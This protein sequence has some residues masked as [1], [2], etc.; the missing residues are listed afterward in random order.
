M[1]LRS[2]FG[3]TASTLLMLSLAACGGGGGG[4]DSPPASFTIGG[5]VTGLA[6][7]T[8]IVL[9]DNGNDPL[10]VN[11]N[12][13]FTFVKPVAANGT[14]LV[15]ITT[16]PAGQSCSVANFQGAG[17]TANVAN[18]NITCSAVT[19]TIAGTVT[20]LAAGQNVVL[21]NN[22]ADPTAVS[23]DGAFAFVAPVA[24]NGSYAVTVGTQPTGQ[25]CTVSNGS[26]AGV[27]ADITNVAVICSTN[28]YTIGG[29]VTGLASGQ[30]VTLNNNASDPLTV[31]ADGT[32]TFPTAV[33]FNGGYAVTVG[34]QP[35][36]QTCTVAG[37]SGAGVTANVA[38]VAVICSTNT[39]AIGGTVAGLASGQQVTLNDNASDPLTVNADGTFTFPTAVSFNGSYAVTVGTQP[40]G[41]T[42][43]VSG[44]SGSGVVANITTVAVTCSTNTYAVGGTITG[45]IAGQQVTLNNNASDPLSINANGTFTFPTPVTFNGS[46]AITVGTQPTNQT[47]TVTNGSGSG[48]VAAISNVTVTCSAN[49]YTVSGTVS[50]LLAGQQ[51]TLNNN[52]ANP[53]TVITNGAFAFSTPLAF[54]SGYAVTVGTQPTNQTCTVSNLSGTV[55]GPVT[56]VAVTCSPNS[57]TISG[58]I[59]GLVPTQQVTLRNNG[60]DPVVVNA[61]GNFTFATP[62]AYNTGYAVTVGTQPT[63][64]TCR[65]TGGSGSNV[66]A[67]VNTVVVTCRLAL[68]YVVN[69]TD[70][71]IAQY[72]IGLNGALTE[73]GTRITTGGTN[74]NVVTVDPTGRF[75]YVT[76]FDSNTV[77]QFSID[78]ATG[79]LSSLGTVLTG[80]SPYSVVVDPSG[81]YAYVT[82]QDDLSGGTASS[83]SQFTIGSDG[84]LTAIG[85]GVV[86][87]PSGSKPYKI[88]V[89]PAGFHAYVANR[90]T[91]KISQ[92]NID[93]TGALVPMTVPEVAAGSNSLFI[94]INPA[95]TYAYVS[96]FG[97]N[98]VSQFSIDSSTGGLV[99]IP[100]NTLTFEV[101]G[102]YP[103]AISPDGQFAYWANKFDDSIKQCKF[104]PDGSLNCS[105]GTNGTGSRPQYVAIDPFSRHVYVVN[106]GIG[107]VGNTVSQ[108]DINPIDASVTP[109]SGAP[110]VPTGNGPFSITTAR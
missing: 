37:G 9:N 68:A 46:Y 29:A 33:S 95:G 45:L 38:N 41:Q 17:V 19:H 8:Q 108:Y 73:F 62:I 98:S 90:G 79:A 23:A 10:T 77:A 89:D 25:M 80:L 107:G 55:T 59:S 58:T 75:A 63:G 36:G 4:G 21:N 31:N 97:D 81:R 16:Q 27:V 47:C 18:V 72:T 2:L 32:F 7:G 83:V 57:Y 110:T 99:A 103:V 84:R 54:N 88:V 1:N 49:T 64:E 66:A 13:A 22:G 50:G 6:A 102:P 5:G 28:T 100:A 87:L 96:N 71:N 20:G 65:V 24:F 85:A 60:A 42:C 106:N 109:I 94:T 3:R 51:V 40:N 86:G 104:N 91:S 48:V 78:A 101:N 61:N 53:T 35:T 15:T 74:P 52:A 39:F 34:T 70:G 92:F 82:N 14:Y 76:N 12:A 30:Q 26:G 56:N 67:D 11:A 69:A 105:A 93:G 44:G 43:T